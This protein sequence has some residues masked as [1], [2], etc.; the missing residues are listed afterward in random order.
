MELLYDALPYVNRCYL[1]DNSLNGEYRL[2]GEITDAT[3]FDLYAGIKE[4]PIW[5]TRYLLDKL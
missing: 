3:R 1:I 4:L 5:V 2:I